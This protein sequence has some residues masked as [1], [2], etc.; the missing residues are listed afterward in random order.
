MI[1]HTVAED[2]HMRMTLRMY[3]E[4]Q[5]W[6]AICLAADAMGVTREQY[7]VEFLV[8]MHKRGLL[9]PMAGRDGA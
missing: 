3:D 5:T 2:T 6:N 7:V 9:L 4:A 8:K 1:A